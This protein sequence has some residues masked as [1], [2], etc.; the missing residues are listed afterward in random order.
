MTINPNDRSTPQLLGD[1]LSELAKL[2]QNEVELAR[3]EV[4]EKVS[5][6]GGAA[7]LLAAGGLL[8]LPALVVLLLAAAL[9]LVQLGLNVPLAY[10]IVGIVAAIVAGG[11]V[12]T[13]IGRLSA[14]AL[15]PRVTLE[16]IRKDQATA[17][18]LMR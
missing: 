15:K 13:G 4:A 5:V 6:V 2:I 8:L 11:L 10:F 7:K 14:G 16:E 17:K 18:E 3:A 9:G 1:A 12:W